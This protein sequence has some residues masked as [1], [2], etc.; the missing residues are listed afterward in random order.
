[1]F[2]RELP[3]REWSKQ[4]W[5]KPGW[6]PDCAGEGDLPWTH[7]LGFPVI[8]TISTLAPGH[9]KEEMPLQEALS[10]LK[11]DTGAKIGPYARAI[12]FLTIRDL[13]RLLNQE[14]REQLLDELVAFVTENSAQS[15]G[16]PGK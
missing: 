12:V 13:F 10:A 2:G 11:T 4:P 8:G 3:F 7:K 16:E 5:G 1:M 9:E 15:E 6:R 14:A